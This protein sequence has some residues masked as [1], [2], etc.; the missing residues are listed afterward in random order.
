MEKFKTVN[1]KMPYIKNIIM[2]PPY[3][4]TMHI[5]FLHAALHLNGDQ[6]NKN[7]ISVQPGA[8]LYNQRQGRTFTQNKDDFLDTTSKKI[9]RSTGAKRKDLFYEDNT[10][11]VNLSFFNGNAVFHINEVKPLCIISISSHPA[12]TPLHV[13]ESYIT[14]EANSFFVEDIMCVTPFMNNKTEVFFQIKSIIENSSSKFNLGVVDDVTNGTL[15]TEAINDFSVGVHGHIGGE[16]TTSPVTPS[17]TSPPIILAGKLHRKG[18]FSFLPS[19]HH[20]I[21]TKSEFDSAVYKIVD[22]KKVLKSDSKM[23]PHLYSIK[24]AENFAKYV[25]SDFA[26]FCLMMYKT[27]KHIQGSKVSALIPALPEY[28]TTVTNSSIFAYFNFNQEQIS[29]IQEMVN[30][31]RNT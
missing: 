11:F 23:T 31:W 22:N 25:R 10:N 27:Q 19:T 6:P 7:V 21:L 5:D 14:W 18:F 20:G 2:N 8:W 9:V 28:K 24:E 29:Y 16:Y 26:I 17:S 4:G 12:A 30:R 3:N 1:I 13:T 15:H